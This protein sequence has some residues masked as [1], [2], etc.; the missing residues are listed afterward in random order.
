MPYVNKLLNALNK[1]GIIHCTKDILRKEISEIRFK[2]KSAR[3]HIT[4]D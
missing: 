4:L 2:R 3:L 1:D